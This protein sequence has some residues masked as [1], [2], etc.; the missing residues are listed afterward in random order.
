MLSKG[1]LP[2]SV[3]HADPP[4]RGDDLF[5]LAS[6]NKCP[7]LFPVSCVGVQPVKSQP[8]TFSSTLQSSPS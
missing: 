3:S 6:S 7:L 1:S 4:H 2:G 8:Q 5:I